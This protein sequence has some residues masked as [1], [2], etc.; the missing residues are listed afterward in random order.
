MI[1]IKT[2]RT[3]LAGSRAIRDLCTALGASVAFGTQGET[4]LGVLSAAAFVASHPATLRH[5]AE[6]TYFLE[7]EYDLVVRP[8]QLTDGRL[9]VP[10]DEPGFGF[11]LDEA[12]LDAYRVSAP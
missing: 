11:E 1:S 9:A 4:G 10:R 3:G 8:P 7:L 2:A 6:L 12:K 5:P